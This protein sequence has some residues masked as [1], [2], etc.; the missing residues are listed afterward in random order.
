MITPGAKRY[1]VILRNQ[2]Y[3]RELLEGV[4]LEDSLEEIAYRAIIRVSITDDFPEIGPGDEIRVSGVPFDGSG[5]VYLLHPGVI[6]ECDSK[7]KGHKTLTVTAYD[8]TIYLQQSEDEN[9]LP[10]GQTASQRLRKYAADWQIPIASIPETG[11]ALSKAVYRPR[12]IH[13]MIMADLKE[14]VKKGGKMYRPRMT[15][16]GLEL[17]ELGTNKTVWVLESN[18]NIKELNQLRTLQGAVTQAKVL[19][20]Q[21]KSRA[22]QMNVKLNTDG[23]SDAELE[24]YIRKYAAG[25]TG[26]KA[27]GKK[28]KTKQDIPSPVLAIEKGETAKYGTIQKIIQ[29][30]EIKSVAQARKAAKEMLA[31]MQ[32]SFSVV[33]IDIN[34]IRAGDMVRLNGLDLLVISVQHNLGSPGEMTVEVAWPDVVKRRVYGYGSI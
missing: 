11:V 20:T 16:N 19:G 22:S 24:E 18:Q 26:K 8:R 29:D 12:S 30:S 6:W 10:A 15:P 9:I 31:G 34:T 7:D 4:T 13:S 3:L 25:S 1:D 2:Y 14:T 27:G 5:M 33:A 23:M 21:E 32:E 17:Y 28:P